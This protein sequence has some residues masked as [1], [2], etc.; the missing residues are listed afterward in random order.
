MYSVFV[1]L[2]YLIYVANS[3][4]CDKIIKQLMYLDLS[5]PLDIPDEKY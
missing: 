5:I 4:F 1:S 2:R 3:P